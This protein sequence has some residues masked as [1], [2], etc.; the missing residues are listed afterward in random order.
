MLLTPNPLNY[1]KFF[2]LIKIY[3]FSFSRDESSRVEA[4]EA[5]MTSVESMVCYQLFSC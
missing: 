4:M 1:P 2:F 5:I 3:I